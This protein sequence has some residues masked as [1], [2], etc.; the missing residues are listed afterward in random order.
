MRYAA[1][2][3]PTQGAGSLLNNYTGDA[4]NNLTIRTSGPPNNPYNQQMLLIITGST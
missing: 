4:N 1:R 2:F 3:P